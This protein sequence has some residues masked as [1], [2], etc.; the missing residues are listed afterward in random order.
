[1]DLATRRLQIAVGAATAEVSVQVGLLVARGALDGVA[2]RPVFLL[3]KLPF[4]WL[5]WKRSAA[6]Y[7]GV[8][9]WEIAAV[10]AALYGR[11]ELPPP[12]AIAVAVTVMVLLGRASSAYPT[13]EFKR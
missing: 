2:L 10:V 12:V 6:G 7:L 4:I 1:M 11:T 9:I 13:V 8:W 5:A 3:A